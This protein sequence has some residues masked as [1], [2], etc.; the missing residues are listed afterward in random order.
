MTMEEADEIKNRD[1][2]LLAGIIRGPGNY[3]TP[4]LERI[5]R[6]VNQGLVTRK[7]GRLYP[8]IKG[9]IVAWLNKSA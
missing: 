1:L 6:L 5:E 4:S 3:A 2:R 8:T 7:K 9:R